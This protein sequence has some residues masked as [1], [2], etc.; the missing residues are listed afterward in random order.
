MA[1]T[2]TPPINKIFEVP[3]TE[4]AELKLAYYSDYFSFVGED[5]IGKVAFAI[6]NNRGQ[7]QETWQADHFVVMH[8]EK[9]GWLSPKGNGLYP[10]PEAKMADIPS[11][12]FFSFEGRPKDGVTIQSDVN[13]L[14]LKIE[15]IQTALKKEKGLS[16]F[17]LG[18]AKATLKWKGRTIQ[19]RVI[20]EFLYLPAFNRLSRNYVGVFKD[21]HGIYAVIGKNDDFYFH[22]Q[23]NEVLGLLTGL[24]LGFVVINGKPY[25]LETIHPKIKDRRWTKG[26]YRWPTG[27]AGD[28]K[29][30]DSSHKVSLDLEQKNIIANWVIGGF[31][32]G[33]VTGEIEID[34]NQFPVYGLAELIL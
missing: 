13:A 23:K 2:S 3:E 11:S 8:D 9:Q 7:D 27:W 12:E 33:I 29:F 16:Q 22:L 26:F 5:E 24:N 18:S 6:D 14:V 15:P 25:E 19:G 10:N 20:H 30:N 4:L 34:G 21:F 31:A 28:F 32:M 17:Q 1:C